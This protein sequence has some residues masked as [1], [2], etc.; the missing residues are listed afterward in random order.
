M[1]NGLSARPIDYAKLGQLYLDEGRFDGRQILPASWVAQS[2]TASTQS[3]SRPWRIYSEWKDH[4]GYYGLHWWGFVHDDGAR[5]FTAIGD[6]GQF[7]FVYPAKRVVIVRTGD[8]WGM[9]FTAWPDFLKLIADNMKPSGNARNVL[10]SFAQ[11][12]QS[13]PVVASKLE[14]HTDA[15]SRRGLPVDSMST[16]PAGKAGVNHCTS[17]SG[18]SGSAPLPDTSELTIARRLGPATTPVPKLP[19]IEESRIFMPAGAPQPTHDQNTIP[20]PF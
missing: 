12:S 8:R 11:T 5:T 2:T 15:A 17:H 3:E 14:P 1:A 10:Q 18:R 6:F 7:V 16:H 20:A 13:F 19:V 9:P 4:G